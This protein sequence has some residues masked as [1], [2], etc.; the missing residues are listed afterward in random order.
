M[1]KLIKSLGCIILV[2]ILIAIPILFGMMIERKDYYLAGLLSLVVVAEG[3][4]LFNYMY[5]IGDNKD[6]QR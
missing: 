6:D 5:E 1:E 2:C 4:G 3:L